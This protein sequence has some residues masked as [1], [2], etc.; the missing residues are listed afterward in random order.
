MSRFQPH[1]SSSFTRQILCFQLSI[2]FST[3]HSFFVLLQTIKR[4]LNWLLPIKNCYFSSSQF[5]PN[6]GYLSL[7]IYE[8]N[9]ITHLLN[10]IR[11]RQVKKFANTVDSCTD[12]LKKKWTGRKIWFEWFM[13]W[14]GRSY[15]CAQVPRP[16]PTQRLVGKFDKLSGL[17][18]IQQKWQAW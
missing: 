5:W 17:H 1:F 18:G 12:E 8:L 14:I 6:S 2:V 7:F 16:I 3:N 15:W 13:L 10:W 4:E 11:Q 9:L